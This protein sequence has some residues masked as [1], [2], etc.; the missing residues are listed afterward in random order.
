MHPKAVHR[1]ARGEESR[2]CARPEMV[3]APCFSPPADLF[4]SLKKTIEHQECLRESFLDR[5]QNGVCRD[6]GLD[7][8]RI[9]GNLRIQRRFIGRL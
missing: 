3:R 2:V 4:R 8:R 6:V 9:D 7:R 5:L 1:S